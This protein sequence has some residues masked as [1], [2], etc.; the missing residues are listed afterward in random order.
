MPPA[1]ADWLIRLAIETERRFM[2]RLVKGAYW[3][4]EIKHA[5]ELGLVGYPVFTRKTNT[6][7]CYEVCAA[8]LLSTPERIFPQFATHNATTACQV[9]ELAGDAS[10]ELQR[11]HGMGELLFDELSRELGDRSV[12][13]RVYAP[14]GTHKDLLPYLVRRLLENG[15]NSSFVNRFLDN[16]VPVNELI[17]DPLAE[18]Q[19]QT[20]AQ[21]ARI[22]LPTELYR[23]AGE[24]RSNSA[25]VDLELSPLLIE[26]FK[27]GAR[28]YGAREWSPNIVK[29]LEEACGVRI[30]GTGF[31]AEMTDDEPE[32]AGY[33]VSP[34]RN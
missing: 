10:F 19:G 23:A 33:E 28:R 9:L 16:H 14:V 21:H 26:I 3:D 30:S 25:G 32:E 31:P 5:Q 15:A 29:R 34:K 2:V 4:H 6:D 8:R 22:P 11:L 12:P 24:S 1:I 20:S 17:H 27:D 13:V 18:V 7:L